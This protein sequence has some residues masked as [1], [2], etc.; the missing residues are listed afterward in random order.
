MARAQAAIQR[1]FELERAGRPADAAAVYLAA[2]RAQPTNTA[3]LLGLER[4]LHGLGRLAE[5][6][7]LA[8]RAVAQDPTSDPLRGLLLR[9]YVALDGADSAAAL[10]LRWAESAPRDDQ[11][12]REWA[13]ALQDADRF[14]DARRV[15]LQG[16]RALGRPHALAIELAELAE[17]AGAW[18]EATREWATAVSAAPSYLGTAA[19]RLR[20]APGEAKSPILA[21]LTAAEA[22]PAAQRLGAEL[23]LAWGEPERG[24][25]VF[26]RTLDAPTAETAAA[27]RRFADLAGATGTP[28]GRRVRGLALARFAD[29]VP[30]ALAWRARADAA[31][32]LLDAGDHTA[33]RRVLEKLTAD[34]MA[35]PEVQAL[36]QAAL[37]RAL[38]DRGDLDAAGRGLD[39]AAG[40]GGGAL[41]GDDRAALRLELSRARVARG[42]LDP[43]EAALSGDS[44]VDAAALRGWIALYR[45]DLAR[46]AALFGEAGP[47]TGR[48]GEATDRSQMLALLQRLGSSRS[49]ELGAALL[50]LARGDSVSALAALAQAANR[51]ELAAGRPELLLLAGQVAARLGG[52][53]DSAAIALFAE[54]VGTGAAGA[55]PP[56]AELEWA[57]VLLKQGKPAD[58]IEHLERLIL[59]YPGSAVVPQARREL[60]RARGAIPKS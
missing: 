16:R 3:A 33:A 20:D 49:P 15:L 31:R 7:P 30:A 37:I 22:T 32:A 40:G 35:S 5:L 23:A 21:V 54:V 48:P 10:A 12:Y 1:G 55:A 52:V 34:P 47:Y 11:P 14:G 44:S 18:E 28:A 36:A 13:V 46:A 6:I 38:I 57:R 41:G 45:G 39:S 53:R 8:Q 26:Q 9:T 60:E 42:E 4:V 24:W 50:I 58:A 59:T 17:R 56:A 29:L 27:L 2:A 43:A 25:S 51:R 19:E